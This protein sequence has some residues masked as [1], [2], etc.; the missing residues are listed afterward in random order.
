M[1]QGRMAPSVPQ[2]GSGL[3]LPPQQF[4]QQPQAYQQI[5]HQQMQLQHQQ[6]QQN[7]TAKPKTAPKKKAGDGPTEG[8]SGIEGVASPPRP[9][10]SKAAGPTNV[11]EAPASAIIVPENEFGLAPVSIN[12]FKVEGGGDSRMRMPGRPVAAPGGPSRVS[13]MES[14]LPEADL[15]E[16][17]ARARTDHREGLA[18]Q[19]GGDLA[20]TFGLV[21]PQDKDKGAAV[22]SSSSTSSSRP[23]LPSFE[24]DAVMT[25]SKLAQ[26]METVFGRGHDITIDNDAIN[27]LQAA[28]QQRLMKVV[29]SSIV[30]SRR[31]RNKS[32]AQHYDHI[33]HMF[34]QPGHEPGDVIPE[35][36]MNLAL[37]WGPDVEQRILSDALEYVK[38][39]DGIFAEMKEQTK[40]E[41]IQL[42]ED[43]K[44]S[45]RKRGSGD[46]DDNWFI[47]EVLDCLK[48]MC[49]L[50]EIQINAYIRRSGLL[51][52]DVCHGQISPCT[53]SAIQSRTSL[54]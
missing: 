11:S 6:Q 2:G 37:G 27:Y 8:G 18:A 24:A 23:S 28:V 15:E 7:A 44:S 41:L 39:Q 42:E 30:L 33:V 21:A 46:G 52:K 51:V 31:R 29:D 49:F 5:Q 45:G 20:S 32:S 9:K 16:E 13:V 54:K 34:Q 12:E 38:E 17:E 1:M 43:R 19:V 48:C 22:P 53:N 25:R 50:Y 36:T 3:K 14:I 40:N 35:H 10:K 4:Q 47:K 26:H